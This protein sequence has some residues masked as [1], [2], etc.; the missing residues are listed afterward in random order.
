VRPPHDVALDA[1]TETPLRSGLAVGLALT[2]AFV[3]LAGDPGALAAAPTLVALG[4]VASYAVDTAVEWA[5]W[6][7][8]DEPTATD[9]AGDDARGD[10]ER[11]RAGD[12]EPAP[13]EVREALDRLRGRYA[14]GELDEATFER[15]LGALLATETPEDARDH[16]ARS[17]G[18][19]RSEEEDGGGTRTSGAGPEPEARRERR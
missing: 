4:L 7:S 19:E 13:G 16:A 12:G 10:R 17:E 18:S 11:R 8:D 6:L 3:L 9:R 14:E 5:R 15:K 2:L 1:V